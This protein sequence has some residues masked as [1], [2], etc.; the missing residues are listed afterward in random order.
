M[1]KFRRAIIF[2]ILFISFQ[3]TRV[4]VFELNAYSFPVRNLNHY[5]TEPTVGE[6][7]RKSFSILQSCLTDSS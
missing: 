6:R 1:Y 2:P 7:Y 4:A 3:K 5:T